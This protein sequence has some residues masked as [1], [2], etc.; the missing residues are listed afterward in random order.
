MQDAYRSGDP[1][2]RFARKA[3]AV[4][5]D[6]TKKTHPMERDQF[7]VVTL[8]VL[9]GLSA[10]G[11]ARKLCVAPCRGR[12]LFQMHR[13]TFPRFWQWSDQVQDEAMLTSKL[14]TVF[15]WCVHVGLD[16]NPRSLRN[17][18]MQGNGAEMLRLACCLATEQGIN[19]RAP[20]HD[21]FLV[22]GPA[23]GIEAIVART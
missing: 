13:E 6:A 8:G 4:P 22:E 3:G 10:D 14:Q 1:Y 7:K 18:P 11:I 23:A 19:V 17:F 2:L 16:P 5:G 15:G 21:A 12:E 20:V 9:F